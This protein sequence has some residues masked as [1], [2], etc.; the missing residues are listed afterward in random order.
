M[1]KEYNDNINTDV[2]KF[3]YNYYVCPE[4]QLRFSHPSFKD[5][6]LTFQSKGILREDS[7]KKFGIHLC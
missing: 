6:N 3:E 1:E 4:G 2:K 7:S 5:Y